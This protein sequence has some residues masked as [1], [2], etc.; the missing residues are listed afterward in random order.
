MSV[1]YLSYLP[2]T[3]EISSTP[4]FGVIIPAHLGTMNSFKIKNECYHLKKELL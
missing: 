3:V 1:L 2:K 4:C